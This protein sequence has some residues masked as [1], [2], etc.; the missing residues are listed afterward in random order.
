MYGFAPLLIPAAAAVVASTIPPKVLP[1]RVRFYREKAKAEWAA[2]Q[3]AAA[4]RLYAVARGH[5]ANARRYT[6][7]ADRL[8]TMLYAS[9]VKPRVVVFQQRPA[10]A[11]PLP[12]AIPGLVAPTAQPGT[13]AFQPSVPADGA[14]QVEAA[15]AA[16]DPSAPASAIE[17]ALP[18]PWYMRPLGIAALLAGGYFAYRAVRGR[19][20]AA[21]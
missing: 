2:H 19:K 4:V 17:P 12:P 13:P 3:R 15:P 10:P 20:S 18:R 7:E 5:A 21:Q 6:A 11:A 9:R 14:A 8:V 16:M 1:D